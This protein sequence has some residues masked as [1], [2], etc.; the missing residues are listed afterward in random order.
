MAA[1][2]NI[3]HI[4]SRSN[5]QFKLWLSLLSSSGLK[6]TERFLLSGER[7]TK[8]VV[9][10]HRS[11]F[12]TA[13]LLEGTPSEQALGVPFVTL[14]KDLFRELDVFKTKSALFVGQTPEI[15]EA[16]LGSSLPSSE[17]LTA[18]GDPSNL[19]ALLRSAEAFGL[20][21]I[22]LLKES[23]HPFHPK[24]LRAS[25]GSALRLRFFRGPSI[26]DLSSTSHLVALDLNGPSLKNFAWPTNFRLLVGQEGLGI[27]K[28]LSCQ[29]VHISMDPSVESLNGAIA[30]S[31]AAYDAFVKHPR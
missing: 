24:C 15:P 7:W 28:N 18:L 2:S 4:S 25:A 29:R 20:S 27:P 3:K 21:S 16:H 23:A 10:T 22:V 5:D 8:E 14:S 1:K 31:I 12:E 11:L 26:Q 6:K 13:L 30:A 9:K 19:G 17:L